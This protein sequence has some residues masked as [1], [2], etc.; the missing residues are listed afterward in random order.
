MLA[1]ILWLT[2]RPAISLAR[3][4]SLTIPGLIVATLVV[5]LLGL[6][7]FR[8]PAA[9]LPCG[10]YALIPILRSFFAGTYRWIPSPPSLPQPRWG[11]RGPGARS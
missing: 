9:L 7:N 10:P 3:A 8:Y 6:H 1:S 11:A 5:G 4:L 2:T